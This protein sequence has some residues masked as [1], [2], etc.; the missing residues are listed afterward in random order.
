MS[1]PPSPPEASPVSSTA[2]GLLWRRTLQFTGV[3]LGLWLVFNLAVP[4]L[5]LD[6]NTI[7]FAGFPLGYWLA[8]QGALL[9][10]LLL[11]VVYIRGMDRL[12]ARYALQREAEQRQAELPSQARSPAP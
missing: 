3:L 8:A 1:K 11:I 9:V 5:A 12:E 2:A 4:L 7:S 10:Y 6:L